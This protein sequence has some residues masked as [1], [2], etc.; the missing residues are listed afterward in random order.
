MIIKN[1]KNNKGYTLLFAVLVASVVL[2]V[3]ISILTISKKEFLLASSARDSSS[4]FY[5][6]D[7][8]IECTS[9]LDFN[10]QLSTSTPN[11][12]SCGNYSVIV[13]FIGENPYVADFEIPM[14]NLQSCA[15][16]TITKTVGNNDEVQVE[17]LSKGY[18]IGWNGSEELCNIPGVKKVE[19][20]I[21][22]TY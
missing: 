22:L 16:V 8:G 21:L 15:K 5:A 6:A 20:A 11:D 10:G 9:Y 4:A 18:N 2:S 7:S 1:L 14:P 17:I 19:R 12:V 3:G 13:T